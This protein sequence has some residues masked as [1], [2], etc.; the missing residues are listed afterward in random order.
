VLRQRNGA[1]MTGVVYAAQGKISD[2]DLINDLEL[3]TAAT[4][5]E[6]TQIGMTYLPLRT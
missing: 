6:L 1:P 5:E 3:L 4:W 2:G